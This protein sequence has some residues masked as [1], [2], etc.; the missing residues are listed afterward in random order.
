MSNDIRELRGSQERLK[1]TDSLFQKLLALGEANRSKKDIELLQNNWKMANC[2][3]E[4]DVNSP[5][6]SSKCSDITRAAHFFNFVNLTIL[7]NDQ[8]KNKGSTWMSG[9][10]YLERYMS[11][12]M[13]DQTRDCREQNAP[14][15]IKVMAD[16][17][18]ESSNIDLWEVYPH[19]RRVENHFGNPLST[20]GRDLNLDLTIINSL[21]YCKSSALDHAATETGRTGTDDQSRLKLMYME[22]EIN[23]DNHKVIHVSAGPVIHINKNKLDFEENQV[24]EVIDLAKTT[25]AQIYMSLDRAVVINLPAHEFQIIF[26]NTSTII[27]VS[28]GSQGHLCGLC[29]G[30]TGETET[31][32]RNPGLSIIREPQ[33]FGESYKLKEFECQEKTPNIALAYIRHSTFFLC[34]DDKEKASIISSLRIDSNKYFSEAITISTNINTNQPHTDYGTWNGPVVRTHSVLVT[35]VH[36]PLNTSLV[37]RSSASGH[38]HECRRPR[39]VLSEYSNSYS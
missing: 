38:C 32:L 8:V 36:S 9:L 23:L 35:H 25:L 26:G 4:Q 19:L 11:P 30:W 12:Y 37:R 39:F 34:D 33:L 3:Q 29:G 7:Y 31:E 13:T 5:S 17:D 1:L 28:S 10:G 21:V 18:R 20:L 27:E 16:I 2:S 14:N 6:E 24:V 22:L 15:R